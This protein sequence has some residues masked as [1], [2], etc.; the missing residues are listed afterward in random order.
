M[1]YELLVALRYLRA[2]RKQTF[3]STNTIISIGGIFLGVA[4][5]IVVLAVMSGFER[6][7]REKILGINSHIVLMEYTGVM[8]D[9]REVLKEISGMK[10]IVAVTPFIYGQSMIKHQGKV[11]GVVIRGIEPDTA[12][13]VI[14]I[15]KMVEGGFEKLGK[16]TASGEGDEPSGIVIG[17]ELA[18]NMGVLLND[19]IE[20]LSPMGVPTPLGM[21]PR[22]KKFK[23]AGIF[24]S[25]FYEYD[26]S[27]AFLSLTDAQNFLNMKD[28]VTGIE[29]KLKNI[30][31]AREVAAAIE[32]KLGYPYWARPWMEMNK[33]LFSALRLEKTVMFIILCLIVVVAA[34]S[35]ITTLIMTVMEKAKDIAILK[36]MGA[37]SRSIMKIFMIQGLIIGGFGTILGCIAGIAVAVNVERIASAIEKLFGFKILPQDVYYLNELPSQVNYGDVVLI[38]AITLLL[39]FLATIYPSWSASKLDPAEAL[40]YE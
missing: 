11:T 4:A 3:I 27:L 40:R 10:D 17:K 5:L 35:I 18:G 33:N 29:V 22:I 24:D 32:K 19:S 13:S 7:L 6:D 38:A 30:Y 2:K 12:F 31:S 16:T 36:S 8:K 39:S 23:V 20:V 1:A 9:Y 21:A 28:L 15:G 25:G 14:S 37:T 34:F 26:S